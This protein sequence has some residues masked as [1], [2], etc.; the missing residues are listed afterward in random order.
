MVLSSRDE[1]SATGDPCV[2]VHTEGICNTGKVFPHRVAKTGEAGITKEFTVHG[3]PFACRHKVRGVVRAVAEELVLCAPRCCKKLIDGLDR[4][5]RNRE[6]AL[7]E[8]PSGRRVLRTCLDDR[9]RRSVGRKKRRRMVA[10]LELVDKP[11]RTLV[12]G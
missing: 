1:L 6:R 5:S 4:T 7:K 10:S 8:S 3:D 2:L 12:G 9:M 11:M